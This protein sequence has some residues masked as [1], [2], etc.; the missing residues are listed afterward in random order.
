MRGEEV[1]EEQGPG[2]GAGID[3][4]AQAVH[5]ARAQSAS[6]AGK[7]SRSKLLLQP[8][9]AKATGAEGIRPAGF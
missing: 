4:E 1:Q 7:T 5:V 2:P 6:T 3:G 8:R 9:H